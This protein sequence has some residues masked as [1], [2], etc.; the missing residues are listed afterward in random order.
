MGELHVVLPGRRAIVFLRKALAKY[1]S[2]PVFLPQ[3][4]ST[5]D[6]IESISELSPAES[7]RLIFELYEVHKNIEGEKAESFDEFSGWAPSLIHDFNELDLYLLEVKDVFSYLSE[8]KAIE[9]WS[10]DRSELTDFEKKYVRFY[11]SLFDYYSQLRERLR[12]NNQ[13]WSGDGYRYVA[14]NI[15]QLSTAFKGSKIVFAGFNA[16]SKSEE[17]I[18][19]YLNKEGLADVLWDGDPYYIDDK[20]QEAGMFLRRYNSGFTTGEFLWQENH[21]KKEKVIEIHGIAGKNGQ[22]R[23]CGQ[24][25]ENLSETNPNFENTAVVLADESLLYPVLNALP[26]CV[27]TCNITMGYPLKTTSVYSLFESFISMHENASLSKK[28]E[29]SERIPGFYYKDVI[30]VLGHTSIQSLFDNK[31]DRD[32]LH[33][34]N[35]DQKTFLDMEDITQALEL[36]EANKKLIDILC[37]SSFNSAGNMIEKLLALSD[38]MKDSL[39]RN[40]DKQGLEVVHVFYTIFQRIKKYAQEYKS[41]KTLRTLRFLYAQFASSE[42]LPFIGEP[43]A[44]LQIMGVLETRLLDF[45]NI[46]MLSVNENILP[47]KKSNDSFIPLDIRGELLLPTHTEKEAVFAYHF[48]RLLQRAKHVDLVYNNQPD[49][50]AGGDKSRFISQLQY[51]LPR[52]NTEI[53]MQEHS[54]SIPVNISEKENAI[55]IHKEGEVWDLLVNKAQTGLSP[56]S[57]NTWLACPLKFYFRDLLKI[58]EDVDPEETID[59]RTMGTVIHEVLEDFYKEVVNEELS[60]NIYKKWKK[61]L[62]PRLLACYARHY[63][64]NTI[65]SG[66]NLLIV[67]V[68]S[69]YIENFLNREMQ[70]IKDLNTKGDSLMIVALEQNCQT[71]FE[72]SGT[73]GNKLDVRF[74]G[75]IDRIDKVGDTVRVV[76]YKTGLVEPRD[77]KLKEVDDLLD[78]GHHDKALQLLMYGWLY[79]KNETGIQSMSSG[80]FS[81]RKSSE[82]FMGLNLENKMHIQTEQLDEFEH[83]LRDIAVQIFDKNTPIS[84]TDDISVCVNC[85]FKGICRR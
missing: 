21:F 64:S 20:L 69:I 50:F 57:I 22:A 28:K 59:A 13:C 4:Y 74:K 38:F 63:Q 71:S 30:R 56:T 32:I 48:Y 41:V 45:E 83:I 24:L 46:I 3:F 16:L 9:R 68:S 40:D 67:E 49:S 11:N 72:I 6:F 44:G 76:D 70:F 1:I 14:E 34:I 55:T 42:T 7:I 26:D 35:P 58:E 27:K 77:L 65:E 33:L 12:K 29:N 2:K 75:F 10:P 66:K 18:F 82:Y 79:H 8:A 52:V 62:K 78:G 53:V 84:Q 23:L 73:E 80:I 61:E 47:K 19:K 36:S 43:L 31:S 51:E 17:T 39:F 5:G 60:E 15:E 81:L 85:S 37:V 25:L 54:Q